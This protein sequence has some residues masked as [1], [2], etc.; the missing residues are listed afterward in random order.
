VFKGRNFVKEDLLV[1]L[2]LVLTPEEG[3]S[4]FEED[5]KKP[6]QVKVSYPLFVK[7]GR[8]NNI[9]K[10]AIREDFKRKEKKQVE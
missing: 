6:K 9:F 1:S 5:K 2:K 8:G 4:E 10:R 7:K 3:V